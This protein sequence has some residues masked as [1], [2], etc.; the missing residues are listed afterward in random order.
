MSKNQAIMNEIEK[1]DNILFELQYS[2][3]EQIINVEQNQKRIIQKI[4]KINEYNEID[5][6]NN[7]IIDK[8]LNKII[9]S[10]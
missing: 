8:K 3:I 4:E 7:C 1:I 2:L 5:D 10:L 9:D 6:M